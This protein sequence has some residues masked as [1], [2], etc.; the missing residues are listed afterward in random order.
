MAAVA[1][2][3][4]VLQVIPECFASEPG[5][6]Q[7]VLGDS[8]QVTPLIQ[9]MHV[10][11]ADPESRQ[12]ALLMLGRLAQ[13]SPELVAPYI[14]QCIA[15]LA[16]PEIRIRLIVPSILQSLGEHILPYIAIMEKFASESRPF[17]RSAVEMVF[18]YLQHKRFPFL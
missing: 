6:L 17:V 10:S 14:D 5:F 18:E 15:C 16:D 9:K 13:H 7:E 1:K 8:S 2:S 4:I 3:L 11:N 12:N